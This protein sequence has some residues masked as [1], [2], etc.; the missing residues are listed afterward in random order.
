M[1]KSTIPMVFIIAL[2]VT[3]YVGYVQTSTAYFAFPGEDVVVIVKED[4]YGFPLDYRSEWYYFPLGVRSEF[5]DPL[6]FLIDWLLFSL[7]GFGILTACVI[8]KSKKRGERMSEKKLSKAQKE[9]FD[10]LPISSIAECYAELL[11][12]EEAFGD[13]TISEAIAIIHDEI[14]R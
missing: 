10:T 12:Y 4:S 3:F 14:N 7:Y 13:C 11:G 8:I 5:F 1:D 2:I 6:N 9:F